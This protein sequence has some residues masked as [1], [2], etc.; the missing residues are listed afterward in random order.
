MAG[1]KPLS[2][3]RARREGITRLEVLRC[4]AGMVSPRVPLRQR[5]RSRTAEKAG[6]CLVVLPPTGRPLPP[7][8]VAHPHGCHLDS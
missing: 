3:E 1:V 4:S 5:R 8:V 7:T 6:H 2:A